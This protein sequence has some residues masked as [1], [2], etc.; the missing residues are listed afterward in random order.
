MHVRM[1]VATLLMEGA[2]EEAP[3]LAVDTDA[4]AGDATHVTDDDIHLRIKELVEEEHALAGAS[5][6]AE[7]RRHLEAQLD[8]A[9]DL[10]RQRHA[11]RSA[12]EDPSAARARPESEVEGYLQ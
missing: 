4:E 11:R 6:A 3:R 10:L 2:A 8:Q 7:R 9:W 12:G 1:K 5:D